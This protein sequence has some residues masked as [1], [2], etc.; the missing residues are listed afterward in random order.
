MS[1][2]YDLPLNVEIDGKS[3]KIRNACD[4]RIILEC[5]D[6]LNDIDL[7]QEQ[8]LQC[9]LV[10]FYEDYDEIEDTETAIQKMFF[11]ISCGDDVDNGSHPKLMDWDKDFMQIA[12]PV[13]RVLGYDIRMPQKYTHW[14]TFVGGYMEIGESTFST[15]VSIRR[16]KQKGQPLEKWEQEFYRENYNLIS[17]P[18][19]LTEEEKDFLYSEEW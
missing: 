1:Y 12:P 6:A 16:K 15:I 19:P 7:S 14:W 18:N 5:I 17:L 9:A 13:S 2:K 11:V 3:F 10:I 8:Q 4:Y